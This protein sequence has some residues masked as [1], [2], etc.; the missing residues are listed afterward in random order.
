MKKENVKKDVVKQEPEAGRRKFL[1]TAAATAGAATVATLGF[2]MVSRAQTTVLKM[3]GAW[4]AKDIFN[5]Y[6]TDYVKR[7]NEMA[8]GRLKIQYLISGAVVKAF[9]VQDAVHKGVLDAGHQV[10]VYWY[11]KSKAA[12][13]FGSGPVFG[14]NAHMGLAWIYYGG[15]LDLYN[16]LLAVLGINT[17]GFFSMPMPTQPLGWFKEPITDAKQMVGLKY[18]TVGLAADVM[19]QMGVKV[20]QLPGGEI[21]PALERGVIDAFE[22][23]NPTSD[24]SFGA[25]DVSKVYMMGSYHQAAE[26][27]EIIFNK[28][29]F[30][31]LADEHKAILKYSAEAAS[32]SCYWRGLDQYS[33]DLQ[34]LKNEAGV[35][36]YRTPTPVMEAQLAAWDEVMKDLMKDPF[37]AKVADSQKAFS[38]R[39]AYYDLLNTADYKLAYDHVFPGELGF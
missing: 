2:P 38:R 17:V 26:Y 7:V 12:S 24:K 33:K 35:K 25:Q 37:F 6:A 22:F 9:Q 13:L 30:N 3:Q 4:G 20:T 28:D 34:W 18:R 23:N 8:G 29:K 1:K 5:D 31:A 11:G 32:S 21:V 15:G 16:E 10:S 27:F 14:Q 19:Q 36:V 39:V